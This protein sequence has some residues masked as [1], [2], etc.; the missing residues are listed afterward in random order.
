MYALGQVSKVLIVWL[1]ILWREEGEEG[2]SMARIWTEDNASL[3]KV[4]AQTHWNQSLT[5]SKS[6]SIVRSGRAASRKICLTVCPFETD[7]CQS[8]SPGSCCLS[9]APSAEFSDTKVLN[10]VTQTHVVTQSRERA[11]GR[12]LKNKETNK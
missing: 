11:R 3:E 1:L 7:Q 2:E 8:T 5:V 10:I 6:G 9:F 12:Y 4:N